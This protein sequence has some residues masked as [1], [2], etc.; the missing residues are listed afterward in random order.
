MRIA[1]IFPGQGSQYVGMGKDLYDSYQIVKNLFDRANEVLGFEITKICFEGPEEE[2]KQ[3]FVTQPAIFIHSLAIASLIESKHTASCAAGHSLGEY[4]ALAFAE[5][6]S[7]DDGLKLVKIR[8]EQ[9]QRAGT[10]NKGTMAA[11]IGLDIS[12]VE[13]VCK[14]AYHAGVVQIANYNSPGQIVISGSVEGVKQAMLMAKQEGAK[15]VKELVVHGAFHSPLMEP[16]IQ[17]LKNAIYNTEI[18][19][20]KMPVYRN[21]DAMPTFPGTDVS[22][23]RDTLLKQLTSSVKWEQ[24]VRNMISDGADEFIEVGPGKVLQGLVKRINP[25][26]STRGFDKASDINF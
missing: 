23:I 8:G 21:V 5:A 2:L 15:L 19:K 6:L 10:A 7:F 26:V 11:V 16:A 1:F 18:K 4:S 25:N 17:E 22:V 14:E 24:S 3:T 12:V 9:M 13:K 20:V